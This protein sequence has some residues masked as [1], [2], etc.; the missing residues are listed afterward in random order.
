MIKQFLLV[1]LLLGVAYGHG[2]L[3][4]PVPRQGSGS[5]NGQANAPVSGGVT[6][7][8]WICRAGDAVANKQ[9]VTAGGSLTLQWNFG[10]AHVGDCAVYVSYDVGADRSDQKW[11]KIA[12]L[13][14][15]KDDNNKDMTI[16]IPSWLKNGHAIFRW[17]WYALHIWPRAE[18]YSQ[19]FD[20]TVSSGQASLPGDLNQYKL[21]NRP[22]SLYPANADEQLASGSRGYRN[23]FGSGDF[24]MTGP[25]C[26]KSYAENNCALTAKGM[27]GYLDIGAVGSNTGGNSGNNGNSGTLTPAKQPCLTHKVVQGDTMSA[28]AKFYTDQGKVVTWEEICDYN[29]YENCNEILVGDDL[30]IP[31]KGSAC[32]PEGTTASPQDTA[33]TA[34]NDGSAAELGI[35]L[36]SALT[37]FL[38]A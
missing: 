31:F 21:N 32:D 25:P 8:D 3:I 26:A 24:Y 19:C 36:V 35:L 37:A 5:L 7:K 27:P 15:C 33:T 34:E 30:V 16:K 10:A 14:R 18:F 23:P 6:G 38:F 2:R 4:K 11:F 22:G 20:A 1:A 9:P 12:N 17:D 29:N 13:P 28:I